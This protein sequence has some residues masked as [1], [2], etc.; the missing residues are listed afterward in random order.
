MYEEEVKAF[1]DLVRGHS[2]V[3]ATGSDGELVVR[4]VNAA[5]AA[6]KEGR[7]VKL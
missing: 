3:I 6:E 7:S 5:T 2:S 1:N 4:M